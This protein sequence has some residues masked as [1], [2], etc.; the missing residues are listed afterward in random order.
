MAFTTA[1]GVHTF[2]DVPCYLTVDTSATYDDRDYDGDGYQDL[3]S[4]RRSDGQLLFSATSSPSAA[5]TAAS[6]PTPAAA[7]APSAPAASSA[8]G[9]VPWTPSPSPAT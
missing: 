6:P 4:I 7:T 2:T 9:G 8:P 1:D 5:P 3:L